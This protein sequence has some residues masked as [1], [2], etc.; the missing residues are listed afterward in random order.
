M[1]KF[2]DYRNYFGDCLGANGRAVRKKLKRFCRID[3]VQEDSEC[4]M[5]DFKQQSIQTQCD[6][7]F[8]TFEKYT[9][10]GKKLLKFGLCIFIKQKSRTLWDPCIISCLRKSFKNF[11]GDLKVVIRRLL[12]A[13][14]AV[15][16][17]YFKKLN[18]HFVRSISYTNQGLIGS[19]MG[20][21]DVDDAFFALS[22]DKIHDISYPH[23]IL[24]YPPGIYYSTPMVY[25]PTP[26]VY[27]GMV[28]Y[29]TA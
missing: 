3:E 19:C 6:T 25:Y 14:F 20:L 2:G 18:P 5:S 12:S 28:Y 10:L 8:K 17:G 27:C 1:K 21:V 9:K 7:I 29:R 11:D 24:P 16:M 4:S 13:I 26:M 23:G 15:F 22:Y